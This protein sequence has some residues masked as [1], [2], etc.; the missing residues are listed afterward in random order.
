M[1]KQRRSASEVS[2]IL[3]GYEESGL[4]RRQYCSEIGIPVTTFDYYRNRWQGGVGKQA[5]APLVNKALTNEE[6]R[7][8]QNPLMRVELSAPA[9]PAA[10]EAKANADFA[11]ALVV[12]G[13]A[14]RIEIGGGRDF[15]EVLLGK[16]IRV[17]E[18]A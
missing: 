17:V 15:D 10:P 11:I 18:T 16:L 3:Q 7:R 14:R 6:M 8:N 4:T 1:G 2:K 5:E 13:Q 12:Q 9:E